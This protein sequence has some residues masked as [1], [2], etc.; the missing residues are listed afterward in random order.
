MPELDGDIEHRPAPF[1]ERMWRI[2]RI[3]WALM[4][5]LLG[6]A[7][8]G[9][10]GPGPLSER[11]AGDK[12]GPIWV[13]YERFARFEAPTVLVVHV[14]P[15]PKSQQVHVWLAR[16]YADRL[17][18]EGITPEPAS[19]RITPDGIYYSFDISTDS[20]EAVATFHIRPRVAGSLGGEVRASGTRVSLNQFA[21]P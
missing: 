10:L 14:R 7:L 20:A 13:E 6:L 2:E 12:S 11:V 4:A 17:E 1:N 16:D 18:I 9:L 3:T 5:A 8:L 19:S 21:Y 15:E